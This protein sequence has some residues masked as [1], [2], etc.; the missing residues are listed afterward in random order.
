MA[1]ILAPAGCT[2][3]ALPFECPPGARAGRDSAPPG[4]DKVQA[5]G[6]IQKIHRKIAEGLAVQ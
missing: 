4:Y 3:P 2:P 1:G 5:D 6:F